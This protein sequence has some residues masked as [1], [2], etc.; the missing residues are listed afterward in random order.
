MGWKKMIRL[1]L[2]IPAIGLAILW[3]S[4]WEWWKTGSEIWKIKRDWKR[5]KE[6]REFDRLQK[7]KAESREI[8]QVALESRTKEAEKLA[9]RMTADRLSPTT[10]YM[11]YQ[12]REVYDPAQDQELQSE[13]ERLMEGTK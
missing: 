13:I 1:I 3:C 6:A 7:S 5:Q 8:E 10:V 2:I 12:V 11:Y 9:D 4:F